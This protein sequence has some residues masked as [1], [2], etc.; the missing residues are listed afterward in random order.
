MDRL[1]AI[2]IFVKVAELKSFSAAAT[3][4]DLSRTLVSERVRDLEEELGVRL[5]QRTTR[6]VSLTE[7]GAAFLER[8]RLGLAAL[9][10]AAAE[11]SS[12]SAEP[13]GVLRVNA[14]MSFGFRHL[15]PAVGAFMRRLS[16][17]ARR[18]HADGSIGQL[19]RRQCRC[20]D[21]HRRPARFKPDCPKAGELPHDAVRFAWLSQT[22][23]RAETP[24]RDRTSTP[25]SSTPTGSTAMNGVSTE[26][27]KKPSSMPVKRRCAATMATRLPKP[28]PRA[29]ASRCNPTSS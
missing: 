15:A 21:P 26:R 13:R 5:L 22:Q 23:G 25:V 12:L 14:P 20:R 17:R 16:G 1:Q 24:S 9:D 8:V 10:E 6:R 11:A 2:E 18:T 28:Q 4:L 29:R 19:D 7:P 3:A 27:A